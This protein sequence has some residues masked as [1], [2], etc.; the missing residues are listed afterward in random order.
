MPEGAD[1]Q[2]VIINA[3]L[4]MHCVKYGIPDTYSLANGVEDFQSG[5]KTLTLTPYVDLRAA[6]ART[7]RRNP[8][9]AVGCGCDRPEGRFH[10]LA[11]VVDF[12]L[13]AVID[14]STTED[15]LIPDL[16]KDH[17][18]ELVTSG[19]LAG[20]PFRV[21]AQ[22]PELQR[23]V[24]WVLVD[25][26][27]QLTALMGNISTLMSGSAH[28]GNPWAGVGREGDCAGIAGFRCRHG[29]E[30]GRE[31]AWRATGPKTAGVVMK[32]S[33]EEPASELSDSVIELEEASVLETENGGDYRTE[34]ELPDTDC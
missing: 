17:A 6:C 3:S 8:I 18:E 27:V 10:V 34:V 22:D 31:G 24:T 33:P 15:K 30:A 26:V 29:G 7:H 13:I 2:V 19:L 12:Y 5:A 16:V 4:A 28:R 32:I 21:R 20:E 25:Q 11:E 14:M 23:A 9:G 1:Q